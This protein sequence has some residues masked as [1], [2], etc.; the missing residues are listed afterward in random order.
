MPHGSPP[1]EWRVDRSRAV[2]RNTGRRDG[3]VGR[4]TQPS[5]NTNVTRATGDRPG[6]RVT[7]DHENR[8]S[9]DIFSYGPASGQPVE[10]PAPPALPT[11]GKPAES[12]ARTAPDP[13]AAPH[14]GP[15]ASLRVSRTQLGVTVLVVG[16]ITGGLAWWLSRDSPV[17]LTVKGLPIGNA[18]QVLDS[19]DPVFR[20]I[21]AADAATLP[22]D[23]GCW[24]A[25]AADGG[26]TDA[27]RL[28]C[29]PV[30]LGIAGNGQR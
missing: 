26:A 13:A 30:A 8:P 22:D 23:A 5:S 9:P 3:P 21:A 15:A 6:G 10:L 11:R 24:F 27:P 18:Q 4:I 7:D 28:A 29:G 1:R 16:V 12:Q 2:Q 17:E 19:A 20:A 25:P 14:G